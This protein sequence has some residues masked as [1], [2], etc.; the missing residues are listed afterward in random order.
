M[1]GRNPNLMAL[2]LPTFVDIYDAIHSLKNKK[3][4]GVDTI[5]SYL[6]KVTFLMITPY[7]MLLFNVCFENGLFPEVLKVSNSKVVFSYKSG[8][9]TKL[10]NITDQSIYCHQA[11][12]YQS[13]RKAT[14]CKIVSL[15]A[16]GIIGAARGAKGPGSPQSKCHQ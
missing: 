12:H 10:N 9:K 14:R 1:K 8:D 2:F 16:S 13:H 7:L 11:H 4:S 15:S 5:L 3:P 6:L